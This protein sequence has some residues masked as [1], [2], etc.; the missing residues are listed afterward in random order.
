MDVGLNG[1]SAVLLQGQKYQ[2]K[3]CT[4]FAF[5]LRIKKTRVKQAAGLDACPYDEVGI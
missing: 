4:I 5:G 1:I 3:K 2:S